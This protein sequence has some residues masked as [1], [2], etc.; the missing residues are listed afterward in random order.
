MKTLQT[1]LNKYRTFLANMR[2]FTPE[3]LQQG[4]KTMTTQ[5]SIN[6]SRVTA[7]AANKRYKRTS[8]ELD[9]DVEKVDQLVAS[10]R[11]NQLEALNHVGLQ[12][13]VYHYRKRQQRLMPAKSLK[14]RKFAHRVRAKKINT[15]NYEQR[16]Q[17]LLN[18]HQTIVQ[19]EEFKTTALEQ[20]L[21]ALK[22]KYNKLKEYVVNNVI[23]K[24]L[25]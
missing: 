20:E 12:S 24:D 8:E 18:S 15:E 9:A 22:A 17:K 3:L 16:K 23:L 13:S 5:E 11:F 25:Q 1:E 19:K 7:N 4:D 2:H 6:Q 14:P 21:I 10:G